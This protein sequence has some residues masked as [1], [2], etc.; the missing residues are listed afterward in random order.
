MFQNVADG[1][2]ADRALG[3]SGSAK[4]RRERRLRAML[5]HERQT[6]AMELAAALHHSRDVGPGTFYG[7]R[8]P[9]TASSGER[10]GVLKE[11]EP[12]NVVDR[13][14]RRTVDQ[15]ADAAPMVQVFAL[16]PEKDQLVDNL[17]LEDDVTDASR[18]LDRPMAEQVIDVPK[19][20]CSPCP[21]RCPI[22]E[23][24]SAEQLVEVP[25]TRIALRIAEQIVDIPA[26][27]RGV[28][29]TPQGSLPEQSTAKRTAS[30]I[31]DIPVPGRGGSGCLLGSLP[32]Q[33]TTN[34]STCFSGTHF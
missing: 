31:A 8:A 15:L 10:P 34:S 25:T 12:S 23:P 13:V 29:D 27:G 5:R 21:S 6:V 26:S 3:S 28:C 32:E 18:I 7:L 1:F 11:L 22:S 17:N 19:I 33:R 9:K 16:V 4:R 20:S 24:Q 14:L 30:Q 2:C